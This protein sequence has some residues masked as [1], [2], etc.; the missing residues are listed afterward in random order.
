M[1]GKRTGM[2]WILVPSR[3]FSSEVPSGV[4]CF[5]RPSA[6]VV[7]TLPSGFSCTLS[8]LAAT[9]SIMPLA[10]RC[11]REPSTKTLKEWGGEVREG[12]QRGIAGIMGDA[13]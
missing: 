6:Y 13:L 12:F 3:S 9:V 10:A 4:L 5:W 1:V 2:V 11:F 7:I 8:P